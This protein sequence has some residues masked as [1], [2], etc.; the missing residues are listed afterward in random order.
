MRDWACGRE[1]AAEQDRCCTHGAPSLVAHSS[2]PLTHSLAPP[3]LPVA[4]GNAANAGLLA[5]RMMAG[6]D[7]TLRD[8]MMAYQAEME[9]TGEQ[10]VVA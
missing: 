2:S 9:S 7:E 1:Y 8:K 6:T 10:C 3:P 5:V 4:I